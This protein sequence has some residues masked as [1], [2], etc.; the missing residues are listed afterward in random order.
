MLA[1]TGYHL[2]TS[3]INK[4]HR[5]SPGNNTTPKHRP[6]SPGFLKIGVSVF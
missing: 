5:A 6:K 4:L 3:G 1:T 2:V